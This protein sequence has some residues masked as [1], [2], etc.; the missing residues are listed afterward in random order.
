MTLTRHLLS[1][2]L[3]IITL[4]SA[5]SATGSEAVTLV[6]TAEAAPAR[7]ANASM[8]TPPLSPYTDMLLRAGELM[9]RD[10]LPEQSNELLT[11]IIDAY[12]DN[13]DDKSLRHDAIRAMAALGNLYSFRLYDYRKAYTTLATA[14]AI[15][16]EDG[17]LYALSDIL[18]SISAIYINNSLEGDEAREYGKELM[19]KAI[20]TALKGGNEDVLFRAA[21]NIAVA[22]RDINIWNDFKPYARKIRK[23]FSDGSTLKVYADALFKSVE[24]YEK[25]DYVGEIEGLR[26]SLASVPDILMSQRARMMLTWLMKCAYENTG[27]MASSERL[28][29]ERLKTAIDRGYLDY[30][31]YSYGNMAGYFERL[32][33]Q[34]SVQK[35]SN[36]FME[37]RSHL[38]KTKG[39]NRIEEMELLS[40]VD[41]TGAQVRQLSQQ[42][43]EDRQKITLVISISTVLF[44][45]LLAV[46]YL[47]YRMKRNHRLLFEK[48]RDMMA[49]EEQYIKLMKQETATPSPAAEPVIATDVETSGPM[50]APEACGQEAAPCVSAAASPV[51]GED[52]AAE[53]EISERVFSRIV[54]FMES[55]RDIYGQGFGI[56]DLAASLHEPVRTVSK[57]INTVR[58]V[59]F[60]QLLNEFR[61]REACRIMAAEDSAQRTVE[62]VATAVGIKSRTSFATLFKKATGLTPTEYWKIADKQR[63]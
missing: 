13:P 3:T 51:T 58:G 54:T 48:N 36:M 59:N 27:D 38:E 12:N 60:H 8:Q 11:T 34:D 24:C 28:M 4:F 20:D 62:Y 31:L 50:A 39:F 29:R 35:Y 33:M 5:T 17:D 46:A 7:A 9:R 63:K 22:G 47:Y 53:R 41:K 44:I 25:G 49:R 18:L 61:I 19:M 52:A 16:E 26:K 15:A 37:L 21:T 2:V 32:G 40:Q 57:A 30:E 45:L 43:Q 23:Y 42:R 6:A 55:S 14:R 10:T 1:I 56:D